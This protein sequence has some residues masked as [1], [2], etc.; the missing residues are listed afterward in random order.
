MEL[1]T[2]AQAGFE[3]VKKASLLAKNIQV[4]FY[5]IYI[6]EQM[7]LQHENIVEKQDCSPVTVMDFAIQASISLYLQNVFGVE[8]FKYLTYLLIFI[9]E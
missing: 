3:I 5:I 7:S 6:N 2:I 9:L 4:F 8:E 1:S